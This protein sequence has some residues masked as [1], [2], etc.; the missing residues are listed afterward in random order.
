M[1][2]QDPESQKSGSLRKRQTHAGRE[3]LGVL[4]KSMALANGMNQK[5]ALVFNHQR[6][7]MTGG[8]VATWL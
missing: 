1:L 7:P 4:D 8:T 3:Y 6:T 5:S 2:K